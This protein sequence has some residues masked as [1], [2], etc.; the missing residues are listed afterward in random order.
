MLSI[1]FKNNPRHQVLLSVSLV[2]V[3]F[4]TA[5]TVSLL[6]E[7]Y[8]GKNVW[9][10]LTPS[11]DHNF[12]CERNKVTEFIIEPMNSWSDFSFFIVGLLMM[13]Y[14]IS[15]L[16]FNDPI[17]VPKNMLVKHPLLTITSA[18]ANIF[19]AIGTFTNHAC[20]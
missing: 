18:I 7:H 17:I 14:G 16:F 8:S 9:H 2:S 5:I 20:R 10:G 6:S 13:Y 1:H 12:W 3:F 19:H 11:G 15:D 4:I